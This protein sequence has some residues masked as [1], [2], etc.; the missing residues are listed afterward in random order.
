[1]QACTKVI[2]QGHGAGIRD[3]RSGSSEK[4]IGTKDLRNGINASPKDSNSRRKE[5]AADVDHGSGGFEEG[6]FA[7]VVASFFGVDGAD[8]V[9]G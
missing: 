1:M 4:S 6:V 9:V 3:E 8:D 7:D 5:S 2:C